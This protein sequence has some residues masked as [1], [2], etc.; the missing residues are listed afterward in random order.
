[1]MCKGKV[2]LVGAGIGSHENITVKGR[3]VL[4][5]ADVVIHD[6]LM[7]MQLLRELPP[8]VELIDVGKEASNHRLSQEEI[9]RLLIQKANEGKK[10]VRLK[11]GDPYVFGRGGE[12]GEV[13]YDNGIDFEVIPG[14][15]AGVAG[16]CYAGIPITHRDF[17][18]S[19]HFITGHRREHAE[20]LDYETYAKLDGTLVFYMG[21]GNLDKIVKGLLHSG[22]QSETPVAVISRG[23]YSNQ[24]V[25]CSTLGEIIDVTSGND[26]LGSPS[27]IVVG[28]VV[29]LREK[30]NFFE[31]KPLFGKRVVVT[32]SLQ[33]ASTLT[34]GLIEL[35]AQVIEMP[36]IKIASKNIGLLQMKIDRLEEYT[37]LMFTSKNGVEIF[38]RELFR[39]RDARSLHGIKLCAIGSGTRKALLSY[40]LRTDIMPTTYVAESL[41]EELEKHISSESKILFP[42]ASMSRDYLK[43]KLEEICTVD[44][45]KIYDTMIEEPCEEVIE[46]VLRNKP[47]YIT[48]TSSS[49]VKN[50][51]TL[52]GDKVGDV[53]SNGK[54][55]I[56]SIGPI[57]SK[58]VIESGYEVYAEAQKH[59]IESLIRILAQEGETV[60]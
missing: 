20:K 28:E 24:K 34:A 11:G 35:G 27:L 13:L 51:I 7:N 41:F 44:E 53:L 58:T 37:H 36:A 12:E 8:Y 59:D 17:A 54:T 14:I 43:Q 18:S 48:F 1:M 6:R 2:Y 25:I 29:R 52:L 33:Q 45:V 5:S 42:G 4:H 19:L 50:T 31:K 47:D 32:R 46:E 30:L 16:L 26:D 55:K 49:T 21:L 39:K 38:M 9:H 15:T 56:I 3:K 60:K 57:T 10:V 40:G 23:G 22:K